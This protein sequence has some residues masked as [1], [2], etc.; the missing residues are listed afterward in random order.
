MKLV[1]LKCLECPSIKRKK[2]IQNKPVQVILQFYSTVF[3]DNGC[4]IH[5]VSPKKGTFTHALQH[6]GHSGNGV[7]LQQEHTDAL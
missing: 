3:F 5:S 1:S 4:T 6:R 2:E 7:L